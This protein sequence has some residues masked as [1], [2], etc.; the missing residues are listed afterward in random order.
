MEIV[1]VS[2]SRNISR[3]ARFP[4]RVVR[5]PFLAVLVLSLLVTGTAAGVQVDDVPTDREWHVGSIEIDGNESIGTGD[6]REAMLTKTRAWYA[7]WRDR[8]PFDSVTFANDLDRLRRAY[9]AQGYY[10][11]SLTYDL[12]LDEEDGLVSAEIDVRE[13]KPVRFAEIDLRVSGAETPSRKELRKPFPK[14]GDVFVEQNYLAGEKILRTF[15]LD[16][17]HAHAET[18]RHAKVDPEDLEASVEYGAQ[19]GPV[20]RFGETEVVGLKKVSEEIVRRELTYEPGDRFDASALR[21][22]RARI[23]ALELFSAVRITPV[24]DGSDRVVVPIRVEVEESPP[25]DIRIGAGYG[26]DEGPRGQITWRHHNWLGDGRQLSISLR[27]S[28]ITNEAAATFVQPFLFSSQRNRGVVGAKVFHQDEDTF[29]RAA[30]Q[31][32]PRVERHLM[33]DLTGYVG[34][35]V[36]YDDVSS[37]NQETIDKIGGFDP[38][39]F[40]SGPMLGLTWDSRDDPLDPSTGEVLSF[41]F[42]QAGVLWGGTYKFWRGTMLAK[43]YVSIPWKTVLAGRLKIGLADSI[44]SIGKLP[45]FERFYSGGEHSV[46]GYARRRLGP[47]S[48]GKDEAVG[49]RS[50]FEGSVELRR[51]IWGKLGGAVFLDF[52]QVSLKAFDPPITDVEFSTGFGISYDTPV[53]PLLLDVGFPFN[54]PP[55]DAS[56]QLHFSIGQFF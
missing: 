26:T 39:G 50:L 53:G 3:L 10:N 29:N 52:G 34:Y 41:D 21:T 12:T 17:G 5:F 38:R 22:S 1:G 19:P 18:T 54:P 9:E 31:L 47:L 4:A 35:R 44:G 32:I 7:P 48:E 42:L 49:G 45:I 37:V 16:R 56:W 46:R 25:R 27:G 51:A 28:L 14:E 8:P 40:L 33:P 24:L 20:C 30:T 11:A 2:P 15:F 23:L 6:L 13:G 36:E 43:K 55:G